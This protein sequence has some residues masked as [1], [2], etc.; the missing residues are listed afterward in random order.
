MA[1]SS[2]LQIFDEEKGRFDDAGS[3]FND[4]V[5]VTFLTEDNKDRLIVISNKQEAYLFDS[6][7]KD[8]RRICTWKDEGF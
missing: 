7:A 2:G 6:D 5:P 8:R 4:L 1:S 3:K